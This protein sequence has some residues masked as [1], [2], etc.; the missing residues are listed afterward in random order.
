MMD[1]Q[2]DYEVLGDR[3][4][5]WYQ[6]EAVLFNRRTPK[7]KGLPLGPFLGSSQHCHLR[8]YCLYCNSTSKHK[9]AQACNANQMKL[10]ALVSSGHHYKEQSNRCLLLLRCPVLVPAV[11]HCYSAQ[12]SKLAGMCAGAELEMPSPDCD[13]GVYANV[14]MAEPS[15]QMELI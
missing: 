4:E 13:S 7:L 12:D 5:A 15:C 3:M 9:K 1:Y 14:L 2:S 6:G 11:G 8:Y 10:R